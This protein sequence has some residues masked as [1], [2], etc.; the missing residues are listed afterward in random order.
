VEGLILK[1][2]DQQIEPRFDVLFDSV[3]FDLNQLF[4]ESK[5]GLWWSPPPPDKWDGIWRPGTM[6][7][8]GR[9]LCEEFIEFIGYSVDV[10]NH[11]CTKPCAWLSYVD[12][13]CWEI[14]TSLPD[15]VDVLFDRWDHSSA[16]EVFSYLFTVP[17][18]DNSAA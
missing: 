6:R 9:Y 2:K 5:R 15:L 1:I 4:W 16:I 17:I 11:P 8:Y 18:A 12:S 13:S 10:N 14:Y 7:L 3:M